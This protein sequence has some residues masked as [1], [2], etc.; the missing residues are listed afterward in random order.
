[1]KSRGATPKTLATI[2]S[3]YGK[4]SMTVLLYLPSNFPTSLSGDTLS[5]QRG[6]LESFVAILPPDSDAPLHTS[7]ILCLLYASN[8]LSA[9]NACHYVL[10]RRLSHAIIQATSDNLLAVTQ[11]DPDDRI[12][13][14]FSRLI[15]KEESEAHSAWRLCF[16]RLN[17]LF[18]LIILDYLV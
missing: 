1:M 15:G 11:D 14:V 8:F 2:V 3:T 9:S 16:Y 12:R 13:R 17:S 4:K 18:E 5:H 7:L 6:L 10:Q